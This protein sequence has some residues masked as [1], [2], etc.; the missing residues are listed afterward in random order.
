MIDNKNI[1]KAAKSLGMQQNIT[2]QVVD[3][4]TG[5]VVQEHTSHNTVTNSMLLGIAHYLTGDGVFQ[6][7]Y[8]MLANYVPRYISLGT[9]GLISQEQDKDG[10]PAGIGVTIPDPGTDDDYRALLDALSDAESRLNVAKDA[11]KNECPYYVELGKC[12][13]GETCNQCSDRLQAKRDELDAAQAAYDEAYDAV[14]GYSEEQRFTDYMQQR[15]GYGADGYDG[16]QNNNRQWF[17]LGKVFKDRD[18]KTKTINCELI[19]ASFPRAEISFRDVVPEVE[20]E[21]PKTIDVVF[22][23]MI[24]TGALK[25]FREEG[26]D[27]VFI[28]ETGLWSQP[29]W[30]QGI[31]EVLDSATQQVVQYD[32]SDQD[33]AYE[34]GDN[35]LLAAYRLAPPNEENWDMSVKENRDLLKKNILRVGVNQIVQIIWKIQ[36]GS[37]D[38]FGGVDILKG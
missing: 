25:Q 16:N 22:S 13:T 5:K 38:Q 8:H 28:T 31:A 18:D 26:K 14:M 30:P 11:L 23:A 27:Y 15:P 33:R 2:I 36:L 10:L 12:Y 32:W 4:L 29:D 3:I 24:S 7:G 21:L 19:S 37:I 1:L 9:M 6:Q 35:G 20:A 17:G 34:C